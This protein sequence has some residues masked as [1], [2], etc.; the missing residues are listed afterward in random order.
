ME[1]VH[2]YFASKYFIINYDIHSRVLHA[3]LE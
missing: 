3:L 1:V 2:S